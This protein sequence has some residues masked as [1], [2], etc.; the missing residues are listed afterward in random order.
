MPRET[1]H[2]KLFAALVAANYHGAK[3][4]TRYGGDWAD[5][6]K[7]LEA[8]QSPVL[9][10][11][12]T[13]DHAEKLLRR[14]DGRPGVR[15]RLWTHACAAVDRARLLTRSP[16][17]GPHRALAQGANPE[18]PSLVDIFGVLGELELGEAD[19]HVDR[20]SHDPVSG[21]SEFGATVKHRRRPIDTFANWRLS[22]DPRR[23]A[24]VLPE[25]FALSEQIAEPLVPDRFSLPRKA[26][27][28]PTIPGKFHLFENARLKMIGLPLTEFRN[29]L[30]IDF[31]VAPSQGDEN[32]TLIPTYSLHESLASTLLDFPTRSGGIDVDSCQAGESGVILEG[33]LQDGNITVRAS[34]RIRFSAEADFAVEL[35][36]LA[37]PFLE[38]WITE[39]LIGGAAAGGAAGAGAAAQGPPPPPRRSSIPVAAE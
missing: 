27:K 15:Q 38:A 11:I 29:V 1:R 23:W 2:Q 5:R 13:L 39:I 12:A 36:L 6:V 22:A 31:V 17:D 26:Q 7:W 10:K 14:G 8:R 20:L 34:K 33:G 37:L 32:G 28:V 24:R 3:A 21:L 18:N 16:G 35:N 25:M 4:T 30:D 9:T 19:F